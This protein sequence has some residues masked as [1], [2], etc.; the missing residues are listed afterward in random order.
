[1]PPEDI[2]SRTFLAIAT[3]SSSSM[4]ANTVNQEYSMYAPSHHCQVNRV[5]RQARTIIFEYLEIWYNRQRR[6]S[7]LGYLSPHQFESLPS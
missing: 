6:H 3:K 5:H 1:M 7:S 4:G 2:M